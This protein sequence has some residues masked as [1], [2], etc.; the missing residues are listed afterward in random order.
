MNFLKENLSSRCQTQGEKNILTI[1]YFGLWL[2]GLY[3]KTCEYCRMKF[4]AV[5]VQ[6]HEF[7]I[8][9]IIHANLYHPGLENLHRILQYAQSILNR[10]MI[11]ILN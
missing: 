8:A 5:T 11:K 2:P 6:G 7:S 9:H 4:I 1:D 10:I 3:W